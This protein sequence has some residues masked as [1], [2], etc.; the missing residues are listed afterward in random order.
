MGKFKDIIEKQKKVENGGTTD[1]NE[2]DQ[3]F[4]YDT[5][6]EGSFHYFFGCIETYYSLKGKSVPT[7]DQVTTELKKIPKTL[8]SDQDR[9]KYFKDQKTD[10]NEFLYWFFYE[11]N[12]NNNDNSRS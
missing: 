3:Q 12:R 9:K 5:L 10:M 11:K 1:E 8:K 4:L 6:L 7:P 2:D